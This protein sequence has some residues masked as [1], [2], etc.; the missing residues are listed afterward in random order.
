MT[1][2]CRKRFGEA[3][4]G[5]CEASPG[6]EPEGSVENAVSL[7]STELAHAHCGRRTPAVNGGLTARDVLTWPGCQA[8]CR[9]HTHTCKQTGYLPFA[10]RS[11]LPHLPHC[12]MLLEL[13]CTPLSLRMAS[14]RVGEHQQAARQ[15]GGLRSPPSGDLKETS[16]LPLGHMA[17]SP[18][19][20][21]D[22]FLCGFSTPCPHLSKSPLIHLP[23]MTPT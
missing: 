14:S 7:T 8:Q 15:R 22:S 1:D 21:E 3:A 20:S 12:S 17:R 18:C 11:T 13:T 4:V 9:V 2:E 19:S 10:P 16:Q 6:P 23:Q 5:H